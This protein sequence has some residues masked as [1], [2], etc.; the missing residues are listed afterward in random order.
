MKTGY[1]NDQWTGTS[2]G[3]S[4]TDGYHWLR[5]KQPE[6]EWTQ[7]AW[8][9]W[10]YPKHSMITWIV[11]NQGL[12]VKTKLFQFGVSHDD[13]C[14]T[15]DNEQ[16]TQS[17]LFFDC[18]YS[19]QVLNKVEQWCG[20]RVNVNMA[21]DWRCNTGA[22]L[23]QHVHFLVWSACFSHIWYQR[24]NTRVNTTLSMPS[25]VVVVIKDEVQRRIRGKLSSKKHGVQSQ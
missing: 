16:E 15:C 8:N 4:I 18:L 1:T 13:K 3:Y 6:P 24:N 25:K 7:L 12:N 19:K 22:K 21:G 23:K 2:R 11:M 5:P 9:R 10:N 20:F 14:C 17:H